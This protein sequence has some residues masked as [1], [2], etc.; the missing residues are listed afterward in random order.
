[1]AKIITE[2]FRVATSN[3]LFNSFKNINSSLS[4]SF[5][6]LLDSYN[7]TSLAGSL[8][9]VNRNAIQGFVNTQL[10]ALRPESYYYI[11]ASSVDKQNTIANTQ[12][13]KRE[14]QRRVIFGNK[15]TDADVRYMF[16]KNNWVSGIVY[17]DFDDLEDITLMN[18]FVTVPDDEGNYLVFKCIENNN[19]GI[20]TVT[21]SLSGI[22]PASYE[23]ISLPDNYIWKYMFTVTAS[24]ASV[25]Q[26][27]DSL[28][29]PYPA[30]GNASVIAAAKESISQ[31]IIEESPDKEFAEYLFGEATSSNNASDVTISSATQPSGS[32]IRTITLQVATKVGFS[33][34]STPGFYNNM[35]FKTPDGELYDVLSSSKASTLKLIISISTVGKT[36]EEKDDI[37]PDSEALAQGTFQLVPKINVSKSTLTGQP[38]RSYG[39]LNQYGKLVR[40]GFRT[41]GTEYKFATASVAYPIG[42]TTPGTTTLRCVV[43]PNGGHGSNPISEMAMSRLAVITNFSGESTS[44]PDTNSYTKVGLVKNPTFSDSVYAEAFDNRASIT[45]SGNQTSLAPTNYY[46]QQYVKTVAIASITV[47]TTYVITSLGTTT[48]F[49]WNT[50]AGT[51]DVTYSVG[52]TFTA[53]SAQIGTGTVSTVRL[54]PSTGSTLDPGDEVLSA[55]IHESVYNS[56]SNTTTLYLVDY[57]GSFE[58]KFHKGTIYVKSSLAQT[59]ATTLSINNAS[60]DVVYGKYTTYSGELLYYVDFDPITRQLARK[61]KI[62]FIFDF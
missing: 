49:Q 1:M 11:M 55:K 5:R 3:E 21:P 12:K 31:I 15:I 42:I 4:T 37:A 47:G 43:S 51:A 18:S 23:F 44:I 6:S 13:E 53:V 10:Q 46:I 30:Y 32:D 56:A 50:A 34:S 35:Y 57:Y 62:K 29:L 48:Q 25:Y 52:S 58:N 9:S 38:C 17:D 59:T 33:V 28:P 14:F 40:I 39:I 61:E 16:Y 41:K 27:S 36:Q 7:T 19:D 24:D 45:L 60:T 22:N 20:S 26:T 8:T 54:V 2:N